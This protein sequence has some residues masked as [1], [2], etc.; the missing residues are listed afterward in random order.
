LAFRIFGREFGASSAAPH[1]ALA[2]LIA[3]AAAHQTWYAIRRSDE[4]AAARPLLDAEPAEQVAIVLA[5]LEH[6]GRLGRHGSGNFAVSAVLAKLVSDLLRR[7]LPFSEADLATLLGL[8]GKVAQP[9]GVLPMGSVVKT[10]EAHVAESG[11]GDVVKPELERLARSW[12]PRPAR[13]EDRRLRARLKELLVEGRRDLKLSA[14]EPWSDAVA[15]A[16]AAMPEED[17]GAWRR[18]LAYG[19]SGSGTTPSGKWLKTA[20]PLVAA[21]GAQRVRDHAVEWF[22]HVKPPRE[23]PHPPRSLEEFEA[24]SRQVAEDLIAGLDARARAAW[25]AFLRMVRDAPAQPDA[26]WGARYGELL[27]AAGPGVAARAVDLWRS[28]HASGPLLPEPAADALRGLVWVC[29]LLPADGRVAAAIGDL[30]QHCLKKVPSVGAFSAK[31]GNACIWTLGAMPGL[32]PVAQLGRLRQRVKYPV[33][34]RLVDKAL[35]AAARRE[36]I[37]PDELEEMAVPTYGLTEPGLGRASLGDF[38]ATLTVAG[39]DDVG[40]SWTGPTG[41]AQKAVPKGLLADH[42]VA[43]KELK[44][45]MKDITTMLPALRDRIERLFLAR[46]RHWRLAHWRARYLDHPLLSVLARRLVWQFQE[47]DRSL[48]GAWHKGRIVDV[49]GAPLPLTEAADV[50]LWHPLGSPAEVVL[51]WRDWLRTHEVR[52]PFKQAHREIYLLTDAERRTATYSNRFA[53]HIIRQHQFAALCRER[54]WR[55]HLQGG[56]DSHNVP[57]LELP[58]WELRV[59][60]WVESLTENDTEQSPSGIYMQVA[61]DQVR[62]TRTDGAECPLAEVPPL[63]FSEA[64]RDVDL[65]VGVTSI[66]ADPAWAERGDERTRLYWQG[67]AFGELGATA[68]TR[69]EVLASLLPRLKIAPRCTLEGRFLRVEGRLRSYKIHLGSANVL[70]EPNDQYLCIVPDRR[71]EARSGLDVKLPF[72]G[73]ATLAVIVSKAMLLAADDRITDETIVRQIRAL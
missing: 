38:T 73:D 13:Q 11:L 27:D 33:S 19:Q 22:A 4:L 61:T 40:L 24:L 59:E 16:L 53:A 64:M 14:G 48:L 67:Y 56:W 12:G 50:R 25:Q 20:E 23:A 41:R 18:L 57:T 8:S 71:A 60:F 28:L 3:E 37:A 1:P 15:S 46:D 52:Q 47:G 9:H 17:R 39:V 10:V 72:E 7:R 30:A 63:V 42:S 68:A 36:G 45:G 51:A 55:Y 66:G 31:V 69:R 5:A 32:E 26:A 58:P 65:F 29:S 21:V 44:R 35:A 6:I 62:F 43:L 54:G 49:G 2:P 34:L 70:M